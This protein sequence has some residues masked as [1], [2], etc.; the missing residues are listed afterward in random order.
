MTTDLRIRLLAFFERTAAMEASE[1]SCYCG[2]F[3]RLMFD[4]SMRNEIAVL[5]ALVEKE[6]EP[7]RF[8]YLEYDKK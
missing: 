2:R 1:A 7:G 5:K 8:T 3:Y 6:P 4:V